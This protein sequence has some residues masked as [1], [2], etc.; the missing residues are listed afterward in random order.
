[1]SLSFCS[2]SRVPLV[3]RKDFQALSPFF[4]SLL[5]SALKSKGQTLAISIQIAQLSPPPTSSLLRLPHHRYSTRPILW[6]AK[7]AKL[8]FECSDSPCGHK[9][10]FRECQESLVSRSK[11]VVVVVRD[12]CCKKRDPTV[13]QHRS[14]VKICTI[15]A[16]VLVRYY[17][18]YVQDENWVI[19]KKFTR[20]QP[21]FEPGTSRTRS[22]NHTPRPLSQLSN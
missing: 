6:E 20:A 12:L 3:L 13:L 5:V 14:Q 10:C 17:C 2:V 22:A 4:R 19:G 8:F 16:F 15:S 18:T 21:G 1:M 7:S 11:G 9:V